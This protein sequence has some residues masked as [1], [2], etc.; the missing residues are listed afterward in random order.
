MGHT[1]LAGGAQNDSVGIFEF[2]FFPLFY[3]YVIF[4]KLLMKF[5]SGVLPN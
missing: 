2:S 4:S 3:F 5:S 1:L